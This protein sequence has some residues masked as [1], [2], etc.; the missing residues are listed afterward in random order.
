M[1][2]QSV[3]Y[4]LDKKTVMYNNK[5]YEVFKVLDWVSTISFN[6]SDQIPAHTICTGD[7]ADDCVQ[8]FNNNT[9]D[10]LYVKTS[11]LSE[12]IEKNNNI[13]IFSQIREKMLDGLKGTYLY[14]DNNNQ[15]EAIT[16]TDFLLQV[17]RTFEPNEE[18]LVRPDDLTY[19]YLKIKE[20]IFYQDEQIKNIVSIIIKNQKLANSN[21]DIDTI[22]RLKTNFIVEGPTNSGK[23][24]IFKQLK[25][26][27]NIPIIFVDTT[28]Y[29]NYYPDDIIKDILNNLLQAANNN[30]TLAE[31]G[32]IVIDDND[33]EKVGV[34]IAIKRILNSNPIYFNNLLF[35]P[36]KLTIVNL[37]QKNNNS[38]KESWFTEKIELKP[39]DRNTKKI[40]LKEST[41]SP[42][43]INKIFLETLGIDLEFSDE[44]IDYLINKY[45]SLNDIEKEVNTIINKSL[46]DIIKTKKSTLSIGPE[47]QYVLK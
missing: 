9:E 32:I 25:R 28:T 35:N 37:R 22:C 18:S 1:L 11:D 27:Y 23:T 44:F 43:Y 19:L 6:N 21:L 4:L 42:L 31:K 39:L 15:L 8:T 34:E 26:I 29:G 46:G 10:G 33:L 17:E 30:Q 36:A 5:S 16:D 3:G 41:I 47:K 45:W 20:A 24:A 12:S 40:I 7:Y 2:E 38:A 13:V 14:K